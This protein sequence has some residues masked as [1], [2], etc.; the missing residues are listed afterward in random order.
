VSARLTDEPLVPR[1]LYLPTLPGLSL[2]VLVK[3]LITAMR[4]QTETVFLD[5]L[6]YTDLDP[7]EG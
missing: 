2:A 7:F 5:L 4:Q 3:M 6:T 1:D